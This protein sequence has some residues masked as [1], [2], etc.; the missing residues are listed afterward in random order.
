[1]TPRWIN[2]PVIGD[3]EGRGLLSVVE[4]ANHIPF[5]I[6]RVFYIYHVPANAVRGCHAHRVSHD[7]LVAISGS[8]WACLDDGKNKTS[9]ALDTP[10]RG[11]HLAP[12]IWIEL[13][14]FSQDC[15][16]L[17]FSS[18]KYNNRKGYIDEYKAFLEYVR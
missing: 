13:K 17:A 15:I 8:C 18:H 12:L 9:V 7:V 6:E 4:A 14:N 16:L 5:T 10:A 1:M 2:L 11:L 3:R